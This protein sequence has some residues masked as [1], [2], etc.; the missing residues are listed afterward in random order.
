LGGDHVS[1]FARFHAICQVFTHARDNAHLAPCCAN[2]QHNRTAQFVFKLINCLAQRFRIKVID[3]AGKQFDTSNV[4]CTRGKVTARARRK[5]GF[6]LI[7][8]FL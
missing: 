2:H 5:F 4:F 8:F 3:C 6:E 1:E 7:E